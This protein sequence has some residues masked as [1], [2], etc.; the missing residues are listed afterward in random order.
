MAGSCP[1]LWRGRMR[2]AL[3][4]LFVATSAFASQPLETETARL[5]PRGMFKLE[6]VAEGQTTI[7]P[8]S[9]ALE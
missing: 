5:L 1:A 2:T 3:A 9:C 7:T 8:N 4:A 6:A